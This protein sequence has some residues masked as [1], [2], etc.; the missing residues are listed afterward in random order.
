ML[1]EVASVTV[2][3]NCLPTTSQGTGMSL[4]EQLPIAVALIPFGT[5]A[6][7]RAVDRLRSAARS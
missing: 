6:P 5:L 1:E 4:L 2:H 3:F 7:K